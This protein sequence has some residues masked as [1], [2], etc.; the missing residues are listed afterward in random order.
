MWLSGTRSIDGPVP[1]GHC[2]RSSGAPAKL[3]RGRRWSVLLLCLILAGCSA[4]RIIYNKLDWL[5]VGYVSDFFTLNDEQTDWLGAAIERNLQWHRRDQLPKYAQFLRQLDSDIS[6][7]VVTVDTLEHHY[8]Q[9]IVLWDELILQTIPDVSAF[10]RTLSEQ[11]IDEFVANLEESN[12]AMWEEYGGKTPAERRLNRQDSTIKGVE[13]A[14]GKLSDAQKDLIHSYQADLHDV[15]VEWI[16]GRRQWQQDF[17]SLV[18]ARPSD[19]EFSDRMQRLLLEPNHDDD[20]DYR[21]RVDA[22]RQIMNAM[23]VALSAGLTDRQ[24]ERFST[25]VNKYIQSF[26]ILA[27]QE[28]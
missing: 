13:R 27:G 25:R 14:V 7:G 18:V 4:T 3:T 5:L 22:N 23:M 20:V 21:H 15:S 17:R 8:T 9:L 19:P 26:E 24:R 12:Q 16:A 28:T 10:F 11:Q 6:S 1:P 2:T